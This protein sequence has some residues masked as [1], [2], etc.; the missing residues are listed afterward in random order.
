MSHESAASRRVVYGAFKGYGD[1][2]SA[3]PTIISELNSGAEVTLLIFPQLLRFV[4]ILDFG[5]HVARLTATALP[6]PMSMRGLRAFLKF[7]SAIS[8]DF[9]WLS[10]HAARQSASW[11]IPILVSWARKR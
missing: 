5:P 4:Q 10:P 3:A 6:V 8:P 2:L 9:V 11:K 7:A 1:L